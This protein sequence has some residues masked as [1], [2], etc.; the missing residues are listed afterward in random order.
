PLPHA[1]PTS[2]ALLPDP[3]E[4][5]R[6][7]GPEA[8][9]LAAERAGPE[10]VRVLY[11]A[12]AAMEAAAAEPD[13]DG[14]IEADIAFHRALLDAGGNRL[15]GSLGRAVDIALEHSFHVSTRTPGAVEAS[16]PVHRA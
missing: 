1:L 15:L 7:V 9:R 10:H 3:A 6:I 12:L 4:L 11:D 5:R 13:R 2:A 16:L 14:Y 8:A